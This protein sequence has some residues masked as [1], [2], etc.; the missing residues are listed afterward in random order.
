MAT[1]F[2]LT[3]LNQFSGLFIMLLVW[4]LVYAV[5][6]VTKV[7]KGNKGIDALLA[8]LVA[9]FFGMSSQLTQVVKTMLPWF[10][11]LVL[12]I[13]FIWTLGK[14]MGLSEEDLI[15]SMG[16]KSG[17]FWWVFSFVIVIIIYSFSTVYGQK[18]LEATSTSNATAGGFTGNVTKTLTNPKVLGTALILIITSFAIRLMASEAAPPV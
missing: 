12:V 9:A 8:F 11:V 4:V 18:L 5:L 17:A 13:F 15:K 3:V 10:I 2:D 7:L 16:N 6:Q 14:F 1:L